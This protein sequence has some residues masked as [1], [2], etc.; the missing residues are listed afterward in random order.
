MTGRE[1]LTAVLHKQ[2]VDGVAWTTLVDDN[3]LR[4]FPEE[5]R[6]NGGID[7]YKAID[8]DIFLLNGWG[9]PRSYAAPKLCWPEGVTA[10]WQREGDT[11]THTLSLGNRSLRAIYKG[12]HPVRY[13]VQTL[14]DI[15]L[16]RAMWEGACYE[17]PDDSAVQRELDSL[18]GDYG[19]VTRFW[20]PSTIPR[21]LEE[22]M[23]V[24]GFYYLLADHPSDME[25]LIAAMHAVECQAFAVLAAGP[26]QSATLVENTSTY[27]ISPA[28]YAR[29]NMPHQREFVATVKAAGKPALLHMCGHVRTILPLIKETG[30]DG[31]HALTPPPTG[32]TLWEAALDVMGDDFIIMGILD[33][34]IFVSGP[35]DDIGPALDACITPR[36]RAA[37]FVLWAAADGL[38][39]PLERFQAVRDWMHRM[40]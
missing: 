6:G 22:D 25:G 33:P 34:T 26:W 31:I 32:D 37:P 8:S 16:Y 5:L 21:L 10:Q 24:E 2:P 28:I 15:C 3:S 23:G 36:L 35:L 18:I 19:V 38:P 13:P 11:S 27:Y 4:L 9:A 39:V 1:R 14:E 29:Y 20:G 12:G 30:S 40:R 7:F 17:A